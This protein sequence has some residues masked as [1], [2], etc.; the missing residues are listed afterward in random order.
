[1]SFYKKV[2]LPPIYQFIIKRLFPQKS[3][4]KV[5]DLGCGLGIA[6]ELLNH[7]KT[8][9]FTGVDFFEPYLN[10]C[11]KNG[12]Y[13]HAIKADLTQIKLTNQSY[14][15]VLL[16]QV[17]EHLTTRQAKLLLKKATKAAKE[18]VIVTLPNG[19][20][21]QEKYDH[22][23]WH[24]HKST[25]TPKQLKDLGFK[26][27]G[28]SFKPIFGNHSYGAGEKA[29]FWQSM[30]VFLSVLIAPL[31]YVKP[32]WGTQLIGVKYVKQK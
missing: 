8:H 17:L 5:L 1:M 32:E 7:K 28:Q 30:A 27:Y 9:D 20:C 29:K 18:C 19:N 21:Y 4:L 12:Y 10:I 16:L 2:N 13:R 22:N 14:D 31:I 6:G 3:K 26:V 24:I 23:K 11:R 25:W 15:A